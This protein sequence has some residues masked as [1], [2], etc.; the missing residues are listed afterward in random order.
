MAATVEHPAHSSANK[1]WQSRVC[2]IPVTIQ[3]T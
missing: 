3:C 2:Y 1:R